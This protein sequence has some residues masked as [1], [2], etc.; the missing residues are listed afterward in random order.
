MLYNTGMGRNVTFQLDLK[1]GA[2]ILQRMAAPIVKKSADA[3]ASRAQSNASSM[4][5]KP[6][7]IKVFSSVGVIKRGSRAIAIVRADGS[8]RDVYIAAQSIRKAKDAGKVT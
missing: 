3:I 7:T 5:S 2:E 6:P 1:G 4:T 8:S